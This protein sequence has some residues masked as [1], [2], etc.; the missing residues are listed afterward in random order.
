[1]NFDNPHI[2]AFLF[3]YIILIPIVIA[4]YRKSREQAALFAAAAPSNEREPLLRELRL[5]MIV[6][7]VFFLLFT[8]F[9]VIALAGPRWGIRI[10]ADYRRGVDVILAFDLS[11]SM[12]V[13]D[14][15]PDSEFRG[16]ESI[17]RLE[18]G[19][20]IAAELTAGLGDVRVGAVIGKGR[21]VAAVP[22]TYDSET[23][24]SFIQSLD[25]RA[26]SGSGTNLESLIDAASASF[27]HAIPSRRAII[28]FS[29]G[30]ELT[31]S[32]QAAV[33]RIRKAGITLCAAGLGSDQGGPVPLENNESDYT[34][35]E[36]LLDGNGRPV[37]SARQADALRSAAEKTGGVY[38]G[39]NRN[40]AA[41]ALAEF[42]NSLSAE[43]RLSGHR[44][45]ANPRW[46]IFV[47]AAM[48]CLY[49]T[50][51]MGFS[52]R[53]QK[54]PGAMKN[55]GTMSALLCITLFLA[56]SCAKAQGKLLIMEGNFFSARGF[57]TEAVSSYLKALAYDEAVPYAEYGLGAA[58]FALE[59]GGAA[60]ERYSAAEN[61]LAEHREDHPELRY[62]IQYNTGIIY[63]EQGDYI[64]AANAFREALRIDGS[65]IEAKR[66]LELSLL[67]INRTG[68]PQASSAGENTETGGE[69][70]GGTDSV[71]FE[72]LRQKEQEQWKSREWA[73]E[74][75]AAESDY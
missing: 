44:R 5:R 69:T 59:E 18:R 52:R 26:V 35:G 19:L 28:L 46:Q 64:G 47:L 22:L 32:F 8:V 56:S 61:G 66:N 53:R 57:Y 50:M 16:S 12:N 55:R 40:D 41:A 37:L 2:L 65:R 7:D 3:L 34:P 58:Y 14:C 51:T 68:S 73:G 6:S 42:I 15:P 1:L 75:E 45:E 17:S 62:R 23:M 70:S 39:G 63:F 24:L 36:Y 25:S 13:R 4:R 74:S 67:T 9:L 30:E 38:A 20:G 11:R 72:Y 48:V 10:V 43:S 21:G 71:I 49:G 33:E 60:L 29:D 31:G 54:K 27:Q